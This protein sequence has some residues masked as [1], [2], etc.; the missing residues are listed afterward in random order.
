MKTKIVAAVAAIALALTAISAVS[1]LARSSG[2]VD[3]N[4]ASILAD[5]EGHSRSDVQ[6]CRNLGY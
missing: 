3:S 2:S 1:A 5:P 6:R 4:C